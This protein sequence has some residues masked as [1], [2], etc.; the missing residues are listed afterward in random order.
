MYESVTQFS[1]ST[2]LLSPIP[3]G[4][5]T[6]FVGLRWNVPE[7]WDPFILHRQGSPAD[8]ASCAWQQGAHVVEEKEQE[9]SSLEFLG[10]GKHFLKEVTS[11]Q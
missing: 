9:S 6:H 7:G 1:V 5:L 10:S 3:L 2:Q 4:V 11:R 8:P